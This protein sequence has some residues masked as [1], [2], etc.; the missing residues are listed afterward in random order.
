MVN[1]TATHDERLRDLE[2]EAFRT[3]RTLAEHS[4][5]LTTIRE[6]QRT[7]FGNI[8]SSPTPSARRESGRSPIA[9]TRSS[10]FCSLWRVRRASTR[11]PFN[12]SAA[13]SGIAPL[14]RR[15]EDVA[16]RTDREFGIVESDLTA[17]RLQVGNLDQQVGNLDA[18]VS[19]LTEEVRGLAGEVDRNQA[20]VGELLTRL[21]GRNTDAGLTPSLWL[22]PGTHRLV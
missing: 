20:Q 2:A 8:D 7:A 6:Q 11:T 4:E 3:G 13:Q 14:S 1:E 16:E 15:F 10:G 9:W 21:V 17:V 19:S 12:L 18:K 22:W 5:Q